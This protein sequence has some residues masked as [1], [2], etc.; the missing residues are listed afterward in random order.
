MGAALVKRCFTSDDVYDS[1]K[2]RAGDARQHHQ[3]KLRHARSYT[4]HN[5][6][7]SN[8]SRQY[9]IQQH[10]HHYVTQQ[11]QAQLKQLELQ[12]QLVQLQA[13]QSNH[14]RTPSTSGYAR[15]M[16]TPTR[17]NGAMMEYYY[18]ARS[19][20]H[21]TVT[22]LSVSSASGYSATMSESSFVGSQS[23]PQAPQDDEILDMVMA[24]AGLAYHPTQQW[25]RHAVPVATAAPAHQQ[26]YSTSLPASS[27]SSAASPARRPVVTRRSSMNA[28]RALLPDTYVLGEVLGTGTT[29][30]CY[31]CERRVDGVAFACKVIDKR[32]LALSSQRRHDIAF[33]LRREV[34]VLSRVD[35]PNIAK[36]EE[37]FENDAYL[38]LIMELLDGGE[39]FDAI[40]ERGRF[41]EHEAVQVARAV[42]SAIQYMHSLGVVHRDL[43]P[44]NM[45]LTTAS[46]GRGSSLSSREDGYSES[47]E[48]E[49]LTVKIIDFG[50][51]KFMSGEGATTT[52]FL[53]TGG[54][55]APEILVHHPYTSAVD[56]WAFGVLLYLLLCGR[57]PFAAS[58]HLRPNQ[59]VKSLYRL[60]FPSKYWANVSPEAIDLVKKLLVLNPNK[61]LT[62]KDALK[63]V[64]LQQ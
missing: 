11:Q 64:W 6:N 46:A 47:G 37:A 4:S 49:P 22:P 13:L 56:M 21:K 28:F 9:N 54:Y 7:N 5:N 44:E 30:T 15:S 20:S 63:H 29:S 19:A 51:A 14:Q 35:H 59:S 10:N 33:Q 17:A 32:K 8:Q 31:R 1:M 60:S 36:L 45:L 58:T 16:A 48:N 52:S 57:L 12:M 50:F 55:L 40:V 62:A 53:G 61:R 41:S 25:H 2:Q 24:N 18:A 26:F 23:D 38:I 34:D 3:H 39:L 42:L 27:A 43:K